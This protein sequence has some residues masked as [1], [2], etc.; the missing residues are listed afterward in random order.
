MSRKRQDKRRKRKKELTTRK[1][2]R[3]ENSKR[4]RL[5]IMHESEWVQPKTVDKKCRG[6]FYF[7]NKQEA[8]LYVDEMEKLRKEGTTNIIE[9]RIVL[10]ETGEVCFHIEPYTVPEPE[11]EPSAQSALDAK[12][13]LKDAPV[14]QMDRASGPGPEG[15]GFESLLGNQNDG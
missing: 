2:F 15:R 14:A 7:F 9:G 4:Y 5:E 10:V 11:Q 6:P 3:T 8:Q 13:S 1:Q 12:R